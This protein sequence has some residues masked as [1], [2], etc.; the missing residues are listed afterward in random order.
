M[1]TNRPFQHSTLFYKPDNTIQG[2]LPTN[3]FVSILVPE[4]NCIFVSSLTLFEK[5]QQ[6][7]SYAPIELLKF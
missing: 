5:L 1:L 6:A 2:D 3:L 4:H 7:W